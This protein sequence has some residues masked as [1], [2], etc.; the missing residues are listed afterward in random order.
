MRESDMESFCAAPVF[1]SNMVLQRDR[2]IAVFG[3][4]T[5]GTVLT[6][7]LGSGSG[8]CAVNRG[9][10]RVNLPPMP[11]GGPFTMTI[12]DGSECKVFENILIGEVWLAGGQSNMELEL[13]NCKNGKREL[14]G[15]FNSQIRFYSVPKCGWDDETLRQAEAESSW[16]VCGPDT[17]AAL[18]AVAYF[19]A[20]KLREELKIPVGIIVCCWGGTS[21]SC[22]M[23]REQLARSKAGQRYLDD[24]AALAGDKTD[25]QYDAEMESYFQEYNDWNARVEAMRAQDPSVTW[26][27]LNVACGVCPWPQPAGRKSP[28]RPGGLYETMV[29]RVVPY[30]I[31]GFLYYQ[32]EEDEARCVD[33]GEMM[34]YLIDQWRGDWG[35]DELPFLFV[36]LPM[37]IAKSEYDSGRDSRHWCV[38]RE[39]QWR[40]SRMI[41]NTALAVVLDC[42]EFDNIH[43]LDKQTVGLRLALQALKTVYGRPV[44]ADGPAFRTARPERGGLRVFFEHGQGLRFRTSPEGSFELAGADGVYYPAKA[45]I[46][47][48]TVFL[49]SGDVPEPLFARYAWASWGPVPLYNA[50]GIP[51]APFRSSR[52]IE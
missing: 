5:D 31:R 7:T 52:L 38:L 42:G 30:T 28:Y 34:V 24:Y 9:R 49:T 1:S 39:H 48:D 6:V 29:R 46:E 20:R 27:V 45:S 36:Q 10:W 50:A 44:S 40:V 4:G 35:D 16:K 11:A 32:G 21:I 43:P 15:S 26:E 51:A 33:Y 18:S 3:T 14:A 8:S 37:F 13:Q 19:C 23:S 12:S 22:W 17:A 2:E 25:A 47:N 41:R